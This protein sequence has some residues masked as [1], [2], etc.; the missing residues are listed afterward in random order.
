MHPTVC[1][2]EV[3]QQSMID[4]IC[5]GEGENSFLDFLDK[6]EK[7]LELEVDGFWFKRKSGDIV[8]N[9]PRPFEPELDKLPFV[10]WDY[11]EIE[12]YLS[13]NPVY[14]GIGGLI[15]LTSRGC[16]Y[17]CN[18]CS[19]PTIR[20]SVPGNY[21]RVRSAENVIEE[22]K[23]NLKKYWSLGFRGIDIHD[24]LFGADWQEIDIWRYIKRERLPVVNLYF[25]KGGRRYRS[26]G[27]ECYCEPI[28]SSANTIKRLL[29]KLRI[30]QYQKGRDESRIKKKNI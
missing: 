8:R 16:P 1:P 6:L 25:A 30:Q 3:I 23:S 29:K 24:G 2:E 14:T 7:G 10:N 9:R 19:A 11:W 5:I 27:C 4:S 13:A 22:V 17:N 20:K 28:K 18:F 15:H 12:K 21:Y 26:I